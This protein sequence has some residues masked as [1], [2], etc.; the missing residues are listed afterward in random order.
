M[1]AVSAG[2]AAAFAV[3][4]DQRRW[5][6]DN[7]PCGPDGFTLPEGDTHAFVMDDGAVLEVTT[8]GP[9][10]GPT[11]VLCHCWT[12]SR[13]VWGAVARRLVTTGHRVV[14]YDQ[15]GHGAS[16]LG[17][18][19]TDTR[20]L[21]GDLRA[22]LEELEVTD[23][24]LAGH[25][26]GGMTIMAL[27]KYDPEVLAARARGVVLVA[28]AA[29]VLGRPVPPALANAM[30]GD[31]ALRFV[32]NRPASLAMVRGS[33]GRTAHAAHVEVTR[34][35]FWSTS[36]EA[37]AGFLVGLSAMDLRPGLANIEVPTTV[38]VGTQDRLTPPRHA[39][40]LA[41]GIAGAELTVLRDAGH[42]LPIEE[43]A[44]VAE[45]IAAHATRA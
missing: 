3:R 1:L 6:R 33:V 18:G 23:A 45:A 16:S 10:D 20:R 7:D 25:S 12:G 44:T 26:M 28:T 41:A 29:K 34:D 24:V 14:L 4:A 5:S 37:R 22:I 9:H 11:V 38:L 40:V 17:S 2:A 30:L 15:R 39:R 27:A 31:R 43:P 32:A 13:A 19:R 42:M 35:L 21:A 8:A 36:A